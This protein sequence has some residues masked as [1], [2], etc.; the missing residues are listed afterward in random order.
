MR[1]VEKLKITESETHTTINPII[2]NN[3]IPVFMDV[4]VGTYNIQT[5]KIE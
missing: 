1:N 4:D 2:Q 3:L 5:E